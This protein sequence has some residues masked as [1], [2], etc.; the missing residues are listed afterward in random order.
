MYFDDFL[1]LAFPIANKKVSPEH[2]VLEFLGRQ[3]EPVLPKAVIDAA[4]EKGLTEQSIRESYLKLFEQGK[5][6]INDRK[7]SLPSTEP[8]YMKSLKEEIS[9]HID[10]LGFDK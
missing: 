9:E 7:L 6:D 5:V 8:E 4:A 2:F 10:L 1:N 3:S